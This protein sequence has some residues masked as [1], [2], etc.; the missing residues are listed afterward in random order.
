MFRQ[1]LCILKIANLHTSKNFAIFDLFKSSWS[2]PTLEFILSLSFFQN[3]K[4]IFKPFFLAENLKNGIY[5]IR[6]IRSL[7]KKKYKM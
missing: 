5:S 2:H 1:S 7:N 6:G 4:A 3:T